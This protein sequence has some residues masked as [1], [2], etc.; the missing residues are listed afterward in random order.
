MIL[1]GRG[2]TNQRWRALSR[3]QASDEIVR[4]MNERSE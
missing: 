2:L 1:T 4:G 3:V